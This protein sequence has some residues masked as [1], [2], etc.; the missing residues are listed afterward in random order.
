[1][2]KGAQSLIASS[3][4]TVSGGPWIAAGGA[5]LGLVIGR[6][7]N[8]I[9]TIVVVTLS[10]RYFWPHLQNGRLVCRERQSADEMQSAGAYRYESNQTYIDIV[11]Q[12]SAW[13]WD[14]GKLSGYRWNELH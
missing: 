7:R 8:R 1:M 3:A 14:R 11:E 5:A 2:R 10:S 6:S 13:G 9:L 4:M 12:H